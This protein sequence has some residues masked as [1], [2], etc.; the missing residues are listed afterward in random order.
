MLARDVNREIF[1]IDELPYQTPIPPYHQGYPVFTSRIAAGCTG[2][3]IFVLLN[4]FT[5]GMED[6]NNR[7]TQNPS[8]KSS[9]EAL[10][11]NKIVMYE[12]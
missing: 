12:T 6:G 9:S 4:M 10:I 11:K 1:N 2:T 5:C 7:R 8:S 3:G